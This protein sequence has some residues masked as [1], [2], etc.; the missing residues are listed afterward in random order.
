MRGEAAGAVATVAAVLLCGMA[1]VGIAIVL[2]TSDL[3]DTVA[4]LTAVTALLILLSPMGLA[5]LVLSRRRPALA[6]F[7]YATVAIEFVAFA[8]IVR[9]IWGDNT[10]FLLGFSKVSVI[11]L[12]VAIACGQVCLLLAWARNG[13]LV[14]TVGS[15]SALVIAVLATLGILEIV[16]QIDLSDRVYGVLAILYLLG[17]ALLPLLTLSDEP[18]TDSTTVQPAPLTPEGGRSG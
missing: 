14:R 13:L 10:F 9:E 12:F 16:S 6:W 7:G 8:I 3:E 11:A 18:A 4:R 5:G 15:A 2:S 1:I 17:V